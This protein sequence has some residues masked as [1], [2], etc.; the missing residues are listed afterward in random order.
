MSDWLEW[1]AWVKRQGAYYLP[2]DPPHTT[3]AVLRHPDDVY[4]TEWMNHMEG[5]QVCLHHP[6]MYIDKEGVAAAALLP[7]A[8]EP[9]FIVPD[10]VPHLTLAIGDKYKPA[11]LGLMLA[12]GLAAEW[13]PTDNPR[14]HRGKGGKIIRISTVKREGPSVGE[15]DGRAEIEAVRNLK[16]PIAWTAAAKDS[17]TQLKQ[18]LHAAAALAALDYD[19]LF[20]LDVSDKGEGVNALLYQ[21]HQNGDYFIP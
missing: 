12:R 11:A 15:R 20:H 18:A 16:L 14:I 21:R 13:V 5:T 9:Y 19:T 8:V 17:F 7:G 2:H 6:D 3:M 4:V 1:E 10:S